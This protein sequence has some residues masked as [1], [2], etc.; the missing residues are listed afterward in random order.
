[1]TTDGGI[2][3]QYPTDDAGLLSGAAFASRLDNGHTLITSANNATILEVDA[4]G[5]LV[6]AYYTA[7]RSTSAS[8]PVVDG[9]NPAPLPTR[10]VR[11]AN[12]DTLISDQFNNQVIEITTAGQIVAQFGQL[13]VAGSGA[14][15]LNAPYDAKRIGDFTGLTK[16]Q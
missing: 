10:A 1:M 9:G 6:W 8:A 7:S 15:Q 3:W 11:L 2:A 16:P 13:N 12:G 14:G 4:T 5:A